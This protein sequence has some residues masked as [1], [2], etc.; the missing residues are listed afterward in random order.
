MVQPIWAI[1]HRPKTIDDYIFQD[2]TLKSSVEKW[3]K[4]KS[5]PHLLLKGHRGT[6][7]TSLVYLL[8]S[9]LEIEDCDFLEKN[10]SK[11]NSIETVR[12]DISSFISTMAVGPFKL[13]LLDEADWLT[14]AA[15]STLRAI[16]ADEDYSNNARFIFT[17]NYPKKI[18]PELRSRLMEFDFGKLDKDILLEKSAEILS[19][20]KV[21]V[22]SIELLEK[23]VDLAYPDF[24]KLLVMLEQNT[25]DKKLQEPTNTDTSIEYKVQILEL[26]EQG[27]WEQIRNVVCSNVDGDEWIDVYRFLYEYL[28]EVGKFRDDKKK[29][30][31]GI[32][33]LGDYLFR[34]A[35]VADPEINFTACII[36]LTEV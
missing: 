17:C 4:E 32:V 36:R 30:K 7:K 28:H 2:D 18:M 10:A 21:K 14:P 13:V 11:D 3:V 24:R 35:T 19:K 25:K 12:N 16:L 27:N 6:G 8:K 26:L 29:W 15:Q 33:I 34:H 22:G 1:K 23:Y 5:I 20:E 31:A 9:L